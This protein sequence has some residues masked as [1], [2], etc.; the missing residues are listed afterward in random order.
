MRPAVKQSLKAAG[1]VSLVVGTTLSLIN[2]TK[3]I[4][5]FTF[6]PQDVMRIGL[7]YLVPFLVASYSR[8][9]LMRETA[10]AEKE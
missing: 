8:W 2:Q 10:K 4:V 7:N 1:K 5:S 6:A 3:A 9:A